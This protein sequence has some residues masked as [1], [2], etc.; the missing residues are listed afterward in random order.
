[1]RKRKKKSE[2]LRYIGR[3]GEERSGGGEN[4]LKKVKKWKERS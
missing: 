4:R 3:E 2:K 1:V